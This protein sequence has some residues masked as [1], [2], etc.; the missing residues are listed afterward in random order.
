MT[1]INHNHILSL[2]QENYTTIH[3]SF[4]LEMS[5][6]D[7]PQERA[8]NRNRQEGL[9]T[10]KALLKD[11]LK[12]DD[13]VLVDTPSSGLCVVKVLVVDEEPK[14]DLNSKFPYKWIVQK[15]DMSTY[16]AIQEQ[17]EMFRRRLVE[18]ERNKQKK[19]VIQGFKDTYP[20]GS[21]ERQE[22]EDTIRQVMALTH[23]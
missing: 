6:K 20:E 21:P 14:I 1:A 3:V 19:A 11:N 15:V 16:N 2:L 22:L 13:M 12:P 9:Y 17:E 5:S 23:G 18:I 4:D 8:S 7:L 10:Y